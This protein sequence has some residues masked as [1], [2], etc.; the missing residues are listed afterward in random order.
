MLSKNIPRQSFEIE[1]KM[2]YVNNT[3]TFI[4][5]VVPSSDVS[6]NLFGSNSLGLGNNLGSFIN[7]FKLEKNA[8]RYKVIQSFVSII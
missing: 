6:R 5:N 7:F 8:V 4:F 1:I 2:N 3:N